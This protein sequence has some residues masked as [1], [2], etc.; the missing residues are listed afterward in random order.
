MHEQV[1]VAMAPQD[2]AALEVSSM[3]KAKRKKRKAEV[4]AAYEGDYIPLDPSDWRAKMF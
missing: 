3:L 1:S 2:S 4:Q